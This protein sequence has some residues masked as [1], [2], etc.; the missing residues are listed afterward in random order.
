LQGGVALISPFLHML[1]PAAGPDSRRYNKDVQSDDRQ[2]SRTARQRPVF[3]T[4]SAQKVFRYTG[5]IDGDRLGRSRARYILDYFER[6]LGHGAFLECL[7]SVA[8]A[9]ELG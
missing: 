4:E 3:Q 9:P 8:E 6:S 7:C 5:V 1:G 2:G